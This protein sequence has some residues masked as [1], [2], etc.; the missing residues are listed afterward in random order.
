[1]LSKMRKYGGLIDFILKLTPEEGFL[2]AQK[3]DE[4]DD[5]GIS[6]FC[7]I[8]ADGSAL[9]RKFQRILMKKRQ[10][11]LRKAIDELT[12]RIF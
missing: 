5:L 3:L 6:D 4:C 2:V 12:L 8:L 10:K 9:S 7:N 11:T 1:M